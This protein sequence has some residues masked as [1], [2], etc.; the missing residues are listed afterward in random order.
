M[1]MRSQARSSSAR[2]AGSSL[3]MSLVMLIVLSL[4][5]VSAIRM[6]SSNLKVVGNMQV[7]KEAIA[8]AQQAIENAISSA[9]GFYAPA[10]QNVSVDINNDGIA[11][12]TVVLSAPTCQ[13]SAPVAG[14]SYA[15]AG[16][17]PQTTYWDVKAVA[18]DTRTGASA[19]IHQ[20]VKVNL[21][22]SASC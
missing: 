20:G 16:I 11:D 4:L 18:T 5:T 2:Q 10:A 22:A 6:S 13:M 15:N 9:N 7:K 12:Y 1:K 8:A 14:Y 3:L 21:D 19:T 17:A